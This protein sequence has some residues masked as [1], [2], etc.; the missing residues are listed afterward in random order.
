MGDAGSS[1]CFIFRVDCTFVRGILHVDSVNM[2][3]SLPATTIDCDATDAV[4]CA[5]GLVCGFNNCAKFHK[6]GPE[7]GMTP[8]SDCCEG[9][10]AVVGR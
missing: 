10:C 1:G 2:N 8:S 7:T 3:V 4:G 6:L 5:D 9:A